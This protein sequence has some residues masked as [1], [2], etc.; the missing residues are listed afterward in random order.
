MPKQ[1]VHKGMKKRRVRLTRG[2][3]GMRRRAGAIHLMSGKPGKK[4]RRLR[5]PVQI[6]G[7]E[8]R[9]AKRLLGGG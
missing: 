8:L 1:K 5:R 6:T 4:R 3:K 2:G 7:G 9:R